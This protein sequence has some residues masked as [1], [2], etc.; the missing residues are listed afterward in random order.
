[1][2]ANIPRSPD[3]YSSEIIAERQSFIEENTPARLDHTRQY[4]FDP[5]A[6]SGNIEN[7]FG[8]AQIPIGIA[9]PLLI[10]GEH[11]T[12]EFFVP[13]A[14]VEGTMLASYNRGMKVIRE[15]GGVITT[16]SAESMQRA[17][18]FVFRNA[19]DARDF[20]LWLR[21]NFEA[22]KAQ[23]ESTTSVGKLIEI[24]NY[25]AHNMIFTRF[26]Y[27]TGDAAGQ[28]MTS[29]ATF[30]ACEW[31]RKQYPALSH[32]LLSGNFDTEKKTSSV[33]MLKGR[34][35]RV[36]AEITIPRQVMIDNLRI[37]PEQMHYG[38]GIST[39]SAFLS[40]SS[41]NAA[42]PANGLAAL[43]LAT[44]QDI[45]NIGESNQCTTYNKVTRAGDYY[46]S[47]TLPAL[48]LATY[49]GGTNLP[50]QRECLEIM[51]CYGAGKA[52]KLAEI[53]AALTVAGELSLGAATRVDKETRVNEWV[54]AHERLGRN[55]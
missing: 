54:D 39:M 37:T 24:E 35:R 2:S 14:T 15:S 49:G 40:S 26:D 33:N 7:L 23:A 55:R 28:N 29:R 1:M 27:S 25:H 32:Y 36:T 22:I 3:D 10:D 19:R 4:S 41:N 8:V 48:I 12:G 43:Y 44:G 9:G 18:V 53:A 6:M 21:D 52:L 30:F 34:G 5:E 47:I 51:D 20:Q 46:F 38:Q 31:I 42:H 13:M 11:A 16:V 50:T 45:A 17:P